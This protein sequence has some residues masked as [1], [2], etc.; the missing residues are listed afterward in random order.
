MAAEP[1]TPEPE[2]AAAAAEPETP[3]DDDVLTLDDDWRV[4]PPEPAGPVADA[5]AEPEPA[6]DAEDLPPLA[7]LLADPPPSN[8]FAALDLLYSLWPR[9]S[10]DLADDDL[11]AVAQNIA[12]GFGRPDR[13]LPMTGAR[14]WEMLDAQQFETA[15]ADQLAAIGTFAREWQETHRDF[16]ILE[17]G[18]IELIEY[19]FEALHPGRHAELLAEVMNLKVLSNRRLGLLRRVPNRM[20]KA[21]EPLVAAGRFDEAMVELAHA[22]ALLER[23]AD[24]LGYAPIVEAATRAAEEVEKQMKRIAAA[25]SPPAPPP[26]GGGLALGRIG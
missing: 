24:P 15:I 11:L 25:A 12:R 16:I 5:T 13:R 26:P 10:R 17:F 18:E 23:I 3:P 14:A 20:R 8:D 1:A 22:K 2:P 7:I 4:E 6:D 19:L 9:G 21:V